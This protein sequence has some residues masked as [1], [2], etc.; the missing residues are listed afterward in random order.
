MEEIM[1]TDP[2]DPRWGGYIPWFLRYSDFSVRGNLPIFFSRLSQ[3]LERLFKFN[4]CNVHLAHFGPMLETESLQR[5]RHNPKVTL[6][7]NILDYFSPESLE[8]G[9][10]GLAYNDKEEQEAR[11]A[12]EG[13][14]KLDIILN[15][16][17]SLVFGG[18]GS[19]SGPVDRPK[20]ERDLAAWR[21]EQQHSVPR[22]RQHE[23]S[24]KVGIMW[25]W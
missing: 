3:R 1:I 15:A 6:D 23:N 11:G 2:T 18:R 16:P 4:E 25:N 9:A 24:G 12:E 21:R 5:F 17:S 20:A 10:T 14:S 8:V 19:M 7:R 22:R 13:V